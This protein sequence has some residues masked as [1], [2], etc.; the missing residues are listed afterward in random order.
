[1]G[2]TYEIWTFKLDGRWYRSEERGN[3]G[4]FDNKARANAI[5][6]KAAAEEGVIETI[7]IERRE[8]ARYN[9]DAIGEK[10]VVLKEA[11]EQQAKKEK[12]RTALAEKESEKKEAK[13][14][15]EVHGDRKKEGD[16]QAPGAQHVGEADHAGAGREGASEK[17]EA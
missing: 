9:G 3:E 12:A 8:I 1:M 14:D 10:F 4:I 16:V 5:A 15:G 2:A 7:L 13:T 11:A 6:G 17:R